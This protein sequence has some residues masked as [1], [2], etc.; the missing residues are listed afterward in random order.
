MLEVVEVVVQQTLAVQVVKL[1]EEQ[2][3]LEVADKVVITLIILLC[4]P[5]LLI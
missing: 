1:M 2:A 5:E 4:Q 3:V